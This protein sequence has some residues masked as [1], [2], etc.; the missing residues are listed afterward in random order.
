[1]EARPK[2]DEYIYV[3]HS[4]SPVLRLRVSGLTVSD[5]NCVKNYFLVLAVTSNREYRNIIDVTVLEAF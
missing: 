3:G 5:L 1:M 4:H 2:M